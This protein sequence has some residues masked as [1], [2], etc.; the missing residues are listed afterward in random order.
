[1]LDDEEATMLFTQAVYVGID[2]TAGTR[3]MNYAALDSDLR[4]VALD[5]GNLEGVLAFVQGLESGVV[6]IDAPQSPNQGLM[7]RPEIRRRFNLRPG[8]KTWG[9]WKVCEVELRRRNVRLYNTPSREKDAPRWMRTGFTLYRRLAA[10]G[11]RHFVSG[12]PCPPRAMI[13]VHPHACYSVL[14]E[15]RPFLKGTLEGRLQR[16]LVLYLEGLDIPNPMHVLEEITRHH[17][18]TG[19]LPLQGLYSHDQ[20]DALA[21]A[22][23]GYL[24]AL[25]PERVCQV[26]DLEE[27]VITLPVAQVK[28][29][30][31]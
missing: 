14:L 15:R 20:L 19:Q 23:T 21:A 1:V 17:L 7:L 29:F 16:Q 2:P 5:E 12:E 18:L 25:K 31:H 6:A 30:Y 13:E 3:P 11:F 27:G 10:S 24:V 28:D 26:G 22:Y 8:G 4:L 9:Q